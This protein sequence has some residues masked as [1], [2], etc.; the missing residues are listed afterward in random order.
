M[1]FLNEMSLWNFF[2]ESLSFVFLF[3]YEDLSLL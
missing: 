3:I 1:I 2:N